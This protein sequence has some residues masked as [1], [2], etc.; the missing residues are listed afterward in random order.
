MESEEA[1]E[2]GPGVSGH[3]AGS[4]QRR[5][6]EGHWGGVMLRETAC[7][8]QLPR[9]LTSGRHWGSPSGK[10]S[11]NIEG[12]A[13]PHAL[14]LRPGSQLGRAPTPALSPGVGWGQLSDAWIPA[15]CQSS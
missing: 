11:V 9:L 10:T 14:L 1:G 2:W 8:I 6:P 5:P 13:G 3:Q 7:R 4:P 12:P 15:L